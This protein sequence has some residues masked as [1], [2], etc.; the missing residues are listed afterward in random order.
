[1]PFDPRGSPSGRDVSLYPPALLPQVHGEWCRRNQECTPG[2]LS[3]VE[4]VFTTNVE[5]ITTLDGRVDTNAFG[6]FRVSGNYTNRG[7]SKFNLVLDSADGKRSIFDPI[8]II[9]GVC[10]APSA[11]LSDL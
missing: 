5:G 1:M 11:S 8:P 3:L 9:G 10:A 4:W 2:S 7:L 6:Q